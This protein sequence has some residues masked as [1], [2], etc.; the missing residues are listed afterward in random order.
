MVAYM[1]P[2]KRYLGQKRGLKEHEDLIAAVA[3]AS[4][5]HKDAARLYSG[6]DI[7]VHPSHSENVGGAVESLLMKIP[8]IT[9]DVGGFPDVIK[10]RQT[11]L[12]AKAGNP[13][14]L[15]EK[16]LYYLDHPDQAEAHAW[17]GHAHTRKLFNVKRTAR[18]IK[19]IYETILSTSAFSK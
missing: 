11:G 10:H 4:D 19:G 17:K 13:M 12:L 8:T 15:A 18:E 1:Y 2:P 3:V 9:T 5:K 7:A 16:I 6:F 14:D